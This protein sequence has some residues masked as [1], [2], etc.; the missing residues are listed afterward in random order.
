MYV[1]ARSGF[2][3]STLRNA[4]NL[5]LSHHA[6]VVDLYFKKN[7]NFKQL[8][9]CHYVLD[10][11]VSPSANY[12]KLCTPRWKIPM[13]VHKLNLETLRWKGTCPIKRVIATFFTVITPKTSLLHHPE[14]QVY[15]PLCLSNIYVHDPSSNA[16]FGCQLKLD[17]RVLTPTLAYTAVFTDDSSLQLASKVRFRLD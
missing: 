12:L 5:P 14:I 16:C 11:L 10:T 2:E 15:E 1:A 9:L 7:W 3:P 8:Y 4:T 17:L 6:P 13:H